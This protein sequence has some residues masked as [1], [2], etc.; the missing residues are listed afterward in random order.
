MGR[1][2]TKNKINQN[3]QPINNKN[4]SVPIGYSIQFRYIKINYIEHK[5]IKIMLYKKCNRRFP[6]SIFSVGST[7][8][9]IHNTTYNMVKL[10]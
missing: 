4:D 6:I 5:E 10:Y 2:M 1:V 7:Y 3:I 8:V 9:S